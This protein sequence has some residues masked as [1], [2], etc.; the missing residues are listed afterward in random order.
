MAAINFA[1]AV[2][3]Y[4]HRVEAA[5]KHAFLWRVYSEL[6]RRDPSTKLLVF[7]SEIDDSGFDV[8]LSVE[9][10]T[11]HLQL[12][13]SM[14]GSKTQS[15]TLRQSLCEL[16]GGAVIWME[17]SKSSLEIERYHLLAF[18]NPSEPLSFTR[19]PTARSIRADRTG[20]K[21]IRHAVYRVP[22]SA[23]HQNLP[24]DAILSVLFNV[25]TQDFPT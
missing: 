11:R 22:K 10:H 16:Q 24:F 17:Y 14:V 8:V 25:R 6:W 23:F 12:K 7:D 18:S 2:Q 9:S 3:K 21:K 13:C 4:S 15:V 5:L 19:F 1:E 20:V